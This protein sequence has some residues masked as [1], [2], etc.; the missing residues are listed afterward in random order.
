[1][2]FNRRQFA[3][4]ALAASIAGAL[5]GPQLVF[6]N[7]HF[8]WYTVKK[9]DTLS[10]LA[11][12]F[13]SSVANIKSSNQLRSDR[14]Q[15]GQKLKIPESAASQSS[16][17]THTVV[18]GDTLSEIAQLYGISVDSLKRYNQLT[19][20]LI[21]IGQTLRL[22]LSLLQQANKIGWHISDPPAARSRCAPTIGR[23]LSPT[24]AL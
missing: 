6:G 21:F 10:A 16:S 23:R 18:R 22:L 14:L 9:G 19:H 15:I 3:R 2:L 13:G 4:T 12:R 24:I 5:A 8:Q 11:L 17:A 1:M 20:D 7:G